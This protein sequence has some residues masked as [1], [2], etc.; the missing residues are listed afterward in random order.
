MSTDNHLMNTS[1]TS[2]S[3]EVVLNPDHTLESSEVFK[4]EST[5][6]DF[7]LIGPKWGPGR[8]FFESPTPVSLR[9]SPGCRL[10]ISR[11]YQNL[12]SSLFKARTIT[13]VI[14]KY[15]LSRWH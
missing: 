5:L 9:Y 6:R 7:D 1:S 8:I 4:T 13:Q 2:S 11:G 10:A 15:G 3:E 14:H 12:M